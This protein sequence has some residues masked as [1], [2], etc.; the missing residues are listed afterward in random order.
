M[1]FKLIVFILSS[2]KVIFQSIIILNTFCKPFCDILT[3]EF[4][5]RGR[6]NVL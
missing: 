6:T 5:F 4:G 2:L 3:K 1:T